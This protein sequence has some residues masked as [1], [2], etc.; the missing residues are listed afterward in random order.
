[1]SLAFELVCSINRLLSPVGVSIIQSTEDLN[2]KKKKEDSG[3]YFCPHNQA[4]FFLTA[5]S[6]TSH[7]IFPYPQLRFIPSGLL[8]LKPL[9]SDY[10][11]P[12]TLQGLWASSQMTVDLGTS[13]SPLLCEP[14]HAIYEILAI[15]LV[16]FLR[17]N[18]TN[19]HSILLL[20]AQF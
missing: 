7:P 18:L 4:F 10:N 13:Q 12:L 11:L 8:V 20:Q 19:I 5:C 1:M 6:G 3:I 15:L 14:V 9:Y 2:I 16:L 17:G